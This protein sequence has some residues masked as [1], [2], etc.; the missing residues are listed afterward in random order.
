MIQKLKK[1]S[2][3][4]QKDKKNYLACLSKPCSFLTQ[5][6]LTCKFYKIYKK[7]TAQKLILFCLHTHGLFFTFEAQGF[8]LQSIDKK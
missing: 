2:S 3:Y 7:I 1:S 5:K 8:L 4:T 6:V